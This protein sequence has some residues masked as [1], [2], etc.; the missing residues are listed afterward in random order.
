MWITDLRE[1]LFDTLWWWYDLTMAHRQPWCDDDGLR[2]SNYNLPR[3]FGVNFDT[4]PKIQ[5]LEVRAPKFLIRVTSCFSIQISP[6]SEWETE[7]VVD[8]DLLVIL[9]D[10]SHL[11]S[12]RWHT[13]N[14]LTRLIFC[15][16]TLSFKCWLRNRYVYEWQLMIRICI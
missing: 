6:Y 15:F 3:I 13:K 11:P 5:N 2:I 14:V 9:W 7:I 1:T 10:F 12:S 16:R 8:M 4:C